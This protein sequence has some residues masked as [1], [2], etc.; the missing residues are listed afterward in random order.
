VPRLD[1]IIETEK[2]ICY[3]L[4]TAEQEG[5]AVLGT[6]SFYMAAEIRNYL[7]ASISG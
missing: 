3:A 4:E 6:G 2:A 5:R 1:F 7:S